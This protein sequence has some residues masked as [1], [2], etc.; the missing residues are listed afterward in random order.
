MAGAGAGEWALRALA[1]KVDLGFALERAEVRGDPL[2]SV[3][4]FANLMDNAL[5]YTPSGGAVTVTPGCIEGT[6]FLC[7]EDTGPG[8]AEYERGKVLERFY[9]MPE[10]PGDGSGLGL[11]IV[12][13]VVSRHRGVLDIDAPAGHRGTRILRSFT[14]FRAYRRGKRPEPEGGFR[15][16][17]LW[18]NTALSL[19]QRIAARDRRAYDRVRRD[20]RQRGGAFRADCHQFFDAESSTYTYVLVDPARATR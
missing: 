16:T 7:V 8:I 19:P 9:R 6:A 14:R 4:V 20:S 2:L 1:L 17:E 10:T 13:E 3:E 11:A 5:R 12:Q 18:S 15:S